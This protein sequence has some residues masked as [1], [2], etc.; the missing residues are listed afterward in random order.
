MGKG[1]RHI[2]VCSKAQCFYGANLGPKTESACIFLW[3]DQ[4]SDVYALGVHPVHHQKY[5]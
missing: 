5:S 3:Q 2:Y 1:A 4:V